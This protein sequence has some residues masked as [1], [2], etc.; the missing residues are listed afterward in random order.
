[1]D[2]LEAKGLDW[3]AYM[4]DFPGKCATDKSVGKYYR[5]HNPFIS[6]ISATPP[7]RRYLSR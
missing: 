5:K 2:L 1:V 3:R 6:E 7:P 4:E